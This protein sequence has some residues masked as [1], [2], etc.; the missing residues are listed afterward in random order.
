MRYF[1]PHLFKYCTKLVRSCSGCVLSNLYNSLSS[2]LVYGFP[3]DVPMLVLHVDIYVAGTEFNFEGNRHY[4][5]AACGMTTF[6]VAEPTATQDAETFASALM[7]IRM[8]HGC[9]HQRS[10]FARKDAHTYVSVDVR[11]ALWNAR[12][13]VHYTDIQYAERLSISCV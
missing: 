6:A 4:L 9:C 13:N 7:K 2:E 12:D 8:R 11:P 5:I 1:W 10:Y 3:V